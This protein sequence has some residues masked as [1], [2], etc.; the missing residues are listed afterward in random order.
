MTSIQTQIHSQCFRFLQVAGPANPKRFI[1]DEGSIVQDRLMAAP[2][3][4]EGR[5]FLINMSQGPPLICPGLVRSRKLAGLSFLDL[6]K[7]DV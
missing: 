7:I 2:V 4:A 5:P 1:N 6:N 3:G